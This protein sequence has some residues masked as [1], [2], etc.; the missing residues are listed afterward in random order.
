[1]H[2]SLVREVRQSVTLLASVALAVAGPLG[3]G[4]LAIRLLG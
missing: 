1:M 4:L 3:L 2:G